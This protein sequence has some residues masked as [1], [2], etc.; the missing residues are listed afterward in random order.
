[1]RIQSVKCNPSFSIN[2]GQVTLQLDDIEVG[3]VYKALE[4]YVQNPDKATIP[5]IQQASAEWRA[6]WYLMNQ[7]A[8]V[9]AGNDPWEEI[10]K[11][12]RE[13]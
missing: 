8:L 3:T 12:D 13:E 6:L 5:H 11:R 9:P 1:M 4:H 2:D 10:K 7:G